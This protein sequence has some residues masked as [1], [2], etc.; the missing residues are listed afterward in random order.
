[1]SRSID[2]EII[3]LR[4]MKVPELVERYEV[5]WGKS[6]RCRRHAHLWRRCAWKLLERRHGGLSGKAKAVLDGL[7]NEIELP[8]PSRTVVEKPLRVKSGELAPGTV[9]TRKWRGRDIRLTV[10]DDGTFEHGGE[11]YTS[12]SAAARTITGS[13][14]NG[15]LFFGV[16][17]RKRTT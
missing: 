17:K 10:R 16:T 3:E 14:W 11:V 13:R 4:G 2:V 6:P 5:L 9:L 1:M 8:D 12:L 15:R 7:I